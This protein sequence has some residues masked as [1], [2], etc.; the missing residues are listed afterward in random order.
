MKHLAIFTAFVGFL[1]LIVS[2]DGF[3]QTRNLT[4]TVYNGITNTPISGIT[5]GIEGL[6]GTATS[7][8]TGEYLFYIP[9]TLKNIKFAIFPGF[10]IMEV[11][12][13]N[14]DIIDIYLSETDLHN[15]TIEELLKIKIT[16]AGKQEQKLSDIPASVVVITREEIETYG[17]NTLEE[18]LQSVPG[19]YMV[20]Q[21]N[22]SGMSGFGVRGFFAE[23]SFSN[24]VVMVNGSTAL[25][26]GYINQY[27]LS[28]IGVPVEA[29][30]RI[31]II[32]G[33]MSVMY[34]NGAFFGAINIITNTYQKKST[35]RFTA[36]YG[37]HN[38]KKFAARVEANTKDVSMAFN[39]GLYSTDGDDQPYTKMTSNP[40]VT[41]PDGSQKTYLESIGLSNDATTENQL[42]QDIKHISINSK[43]KGFTF[44]V[45]TTR[46]E[47]GLLWMAPS[48]S[49][50][51]QNVLINASD[52]RF[53]YQ[54]PFGKHLKL[55]TLLTYG[56]YNSISRYNIQATAGAGH[57]HINSTNVFLEINGIYKPQDKFDITLGVVREALLNASNDVDIPNFGVANSSWRIKLGDKI[58]DY[59]VYSQLN[60]KPFKKV[61]VIAGIR[62]T[63]YGDY[64]YQRLI[65][66]GL[67]TAK[68]FAKEFTDNKIHLTGRLAAI[69]KINEN[70]IFKLMYGT[71]IISPNLR[72]NVTRLDLSGG[73]RTQL[74]PSSITTYEFSYSALL[75]NVLYTNFSVFHNNLDK[76]I[77]SS[78]ATDANGKYLVITQ[79]TGKIKTNGVELSLQLKPFSGLDMLLSATYQKS[80]NTKKGWEDIELGYSPQLLCYVKVAYKSPRNLTVGIT[81]NYVDAM[82]TS[83]LQ[84]NINPQLGIR[85][86]NKVDTHFCLNA[87]IMIDRL[88][89]MPNISISANV[90]N[91][92][93]TDIYS[94][95]D[96]SNQWADKGFI[97]YGRRM[98]LRFGYKF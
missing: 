38:T 50:H 9:D 84:N 58:Q 32:R 79:N 76:L 14:F 20:E 21:Y 56:A 7:A 92:F 27:I 91:I 44:D 31:E 18:I 68:I 77:E 13:V 49:P 89:K 39:V 48:P 41:L 26:E 43:Y 42:S 69:L 3:A 12:H 85:Y 74:E 36:M 6:K 72:Q 94:A 30:D 40:L 2:C 82:E 88:L 93:D 37:S 28:R 78:G 59:E 70:N 63:K 34:G 19:L 22:W 55:N 90:T 46:A 73:N 29:I 8:E 51:G 62:T 24:M 95:T 45:G 15:L 35:N 98:M 47:K 11:R 87:N 64:T 5:I 97:G 75:S 66:E 71:A 60:Y 1:W 54:H 86:G 16:T 23:G 67:P 52:A 25:R 4:G 80:V 17:F 10:D 81:G 57:S 83:W 33:P 61:H 53:Q 65:D 96:P